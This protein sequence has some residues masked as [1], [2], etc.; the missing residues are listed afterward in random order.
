MLLSLSGVPFGT[1]SLQELEELEL[2]KK[3]G[4][5]EAFIQVLRDQ[6]NNQGCLMSLIIFIFTFVA[7]FSLIKRC[8]WDGRHLYPIQR[9]HHV[10]IQF[11]VICLFFFHHVE[12]LIKQLLQFVSQIVNGQKLFTSP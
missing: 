1:A 8:T 6:A 2:C 3:I 10:E 11:F 12:T 9:A 7:H 4:L 5:L